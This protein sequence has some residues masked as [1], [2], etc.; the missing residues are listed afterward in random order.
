[1]TLSEKIDAIAD[2]VSNL[3]RFGFINEKEANAL[4]RYYALKV[5]DQCRQE[6]EEGKPELDLL[7]ELLTRPTK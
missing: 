2:F 3:E 6:L 1:M 4:V 7:V 5:A